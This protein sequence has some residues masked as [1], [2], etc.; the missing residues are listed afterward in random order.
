MVEC[1]WAVWRLRRPKASGAKGD[2]RFAVVGSATTEEVAFRSLRS[3]HAT[4]REV[5]PTTAGYAG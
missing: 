4:M 3:L 1:V 5:E 2:V